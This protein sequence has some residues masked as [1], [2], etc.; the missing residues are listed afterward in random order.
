[1]GFCIQLYF[2][3]DEIVKH[4]RQECINYVTKFYLALGGDYKSTVGVMLG[5][6]FERLL[7]SLISAK[8]MECREFGDSKSAVYDIKHG[9]SFKKVDTHGTMSIEEAIQKGGNDM[10]LYDYGRSMPGIDAFIPAGTATN[11]T[12]DVIINNDMY[13]QI[14]H[15][16]ADKP[17]KLLNLNVLFQIALRN[18]D[19]NVRECKS[20]K[21]DFIVTIPHSQKDI[22]TTLPSIKVNDKTTCDAIIS[23]ENK[24][25]DNEVLENEEKDDKVL[26]LNGQRTF[27]KLPDKQRTLIKDNIRFLVGSVRT[28]HSGAAGRRSSTIPSMYPLTLP[29]SMRS[30]NLGTSAATPKSNC[31]A[32][33]WFPKIVK[34][35]R[36]L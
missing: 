17:T 9:L 27:S 14:T 34:L 30:I 6:I 20:G 15:S 8:G 24:T 22:F 31:V 11:S 1:M 10:M 19:K 12:D 29:L 2:R 26:K 33:S 16:I 4:H 18:Q 13:L 21:A 7:A 25:E 36:L 35:F 28:F 32:V 23:I 3:L 5:R